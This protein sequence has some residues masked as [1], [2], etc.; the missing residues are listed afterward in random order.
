[1]LPETLI[2]IK[3]SKKHINTIE[4]KDR[5]VKESLEEL[6]EYLSGASTMIAFPEIV[7]PID[8]ILRKFR[9]GS[10]NNNQTVPCLH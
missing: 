6:L 5:I 4:Q 3:I 7:V 10:T 9:K 1:M 8:Q 2:S